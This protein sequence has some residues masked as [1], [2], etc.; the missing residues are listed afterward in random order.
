MHG[1]PVS[2]V[3]LLFWRNLLAGELT[4]VEPW[5]EQMEALVLKSNS[6]QLQKMEL[7]VIKY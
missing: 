6:K 5:V 3:L 7:S 1:Q 4:E 2:S